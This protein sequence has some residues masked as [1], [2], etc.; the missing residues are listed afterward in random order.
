MPYTTENI[1]G[2]EA[3]I[4]DREEQIERLRTNPPSGWAPR[5]VTHNIDLLEEQIAGFQKTI[6]KIRT[7]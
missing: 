1:A 5:Y 7:A 3:S 4:A 6:E 2:F